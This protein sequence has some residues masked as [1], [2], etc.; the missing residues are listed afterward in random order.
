VLGSLADLP[1]LPGR[2]GAASAQERATTEKQE[3]K[4]K[5]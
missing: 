4:K 3:A 1:T 5:G 2:V